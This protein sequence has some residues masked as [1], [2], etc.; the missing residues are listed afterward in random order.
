MSQKQA[1]LTKWR[2][3]AGQ[4]INN[5]HR[6]IQNESQSDTYLKK[7]FLQQKLTN[8]LNNT[9]DQR[10]GHKMPIKTNSTF[11]IG[12]RN[13]NS[14]PVMSSHS[15]NHIFT[16]DIREGEFDVFCATEVNV[17]WQN[18]PEQDRIQERFR[19]H[20]EF[21]KYVYSN[22]KDAEFK[23]KYQRGGTLT[24]CQGPSCGRVI[25]WGSDPTLLGRWSWVKIR[26][27]N[28][29]QL[30]VVTLYRPVISQGALSTY[31]QHKNIL[32]DKDI[33]ECPRKVILDDLQQEIIKWKDEAMKTI[34]IWIFPI[35]GHL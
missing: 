13:I 15:K 16:N 35:L 21:A 8:T 2:T 1:T 32:L 12:L 14:L 11:R 4:S 31:Q 5:S 18:V 23:E 6:I 17:A 10:W 22:N 33:D 28:G 26:G 7:N 20:L 30:L 9:T 19:G 24:I 3:S 34:S 29:L 25:E 27:C